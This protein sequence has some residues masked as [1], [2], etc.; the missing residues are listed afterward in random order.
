MNQWIG[1][2]IIA[3]TLYLLK[4]MNEW[5]LML[6]LMLEISIYALLRK[7]DNMEKGIKDEDDPLFRT[8]RNPYI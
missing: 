2:L 8:K 6:I 5:V 1:V 7:I 3:L 4:G